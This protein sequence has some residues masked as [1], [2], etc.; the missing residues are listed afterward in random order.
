MQVITYDSKKS[1]KNNVIKCITN[2]KGFY[3]KTD[4]TIRIQ[5]QDEIRERV[6]LVRKRKVNPILYNKII[7]QRV[8]GNLSSHI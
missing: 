6:F 2:T 3:K 7:R 8:A 4:D 1:Y 5:L